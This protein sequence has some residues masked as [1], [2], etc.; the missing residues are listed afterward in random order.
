M[1]KLFAPTI[2]NKQYS[3]PTTG[4][5][6]SKDILTGYVNLFWND[7]FKSLSEKK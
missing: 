6:L 5:C 3:L 4:L 2:A 7:I 1:K